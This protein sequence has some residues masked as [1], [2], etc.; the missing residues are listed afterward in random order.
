[1]S[2]LDR[3]LWRACWGLAGKRRRAV[4]NEL[5]AN[6]VQH[7]LDLQVAGL[8]QPEALRQA[9]R[10]FGS[11]RRVNLALHRVHTLPAVLNSV[12]LTVS[13]STAALGLF[14]WSRAAGRE[15]QA[16]CPV[17]VEHGAPPSGHCHP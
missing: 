4:E 8:S 15:H 9:V 1:M 14:S 10:E 16:T 7:A 13:L 2:D 11:A 3:Y 6:I 12:L 5:R 17:Q